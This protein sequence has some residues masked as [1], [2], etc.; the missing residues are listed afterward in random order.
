[1]VDPE[2]GAHSAKSPVLF[3]KIGS[4]GIQNTILDVMAPGSAHGEEGVPLQIKDL[5]T[6]QM[7]YMGPNALDFPTV[8]FLYGVLSQQVEVFMVAADKQRGKRQVFQ[9]V[10][11]AGI[12]FAAFPYT[13]EV[14][15]ITN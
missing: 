14:A 12:L 5:P 6:H 10:Q 11:A 2:A 9:P 8:P 3:F 7:D 4:F 15:V 13:A 1:M